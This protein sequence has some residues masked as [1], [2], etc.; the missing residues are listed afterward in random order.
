MA[1]ELPT[2]LWYRIIQFLPTTHQKTCLSV[3]KMHHDIA[4]KYV[5]SHVIISLGLWRADDEIE[6]APTPVQLLVAKRVARANYALLRH[7]MRTP[8]FACHVRKL[9]VQSYSFFEGNHMEYEIGT[10][11]DAIETLHNLSSF[12]WYGPLP[13]T[14]CEIM[15]ALRRS[16]GQKVVDIL[17]HPEI[18][19]HICLPAFTQLKSLVFVHRHGTHWPA[20]DAVPYHKTIHA[21][22]SA[23]SAT[24]RRLDVFGDALWGCPSAFFSNL[25]ELAIVFP[26]TLDGLHSVFEHCRGLGGFTLCTENDSSEFASILTAYPDAFPSLASFKLLS[27]FDFH[28]EAIRE[29][30]QFLKKKKLL[31]R[32]DILTRTEN[33]LHG[34]ANTPILEILP[35]LPRLEVLGLDIRPLKLTSAHV[36]LLQQYIPRQITAL[37]LLLQVESSSAKVGDWHTFFAAHAALQY[38]HIVTSAPQTDSLGAA[39]FDQPLPALELLGYNSRLRWVTRGPTPSGTT[40][41]SYSECWPRAKAYF[42]TVE[43]F[44]GY[45]DWEWLAR[46]H[47]QDDDDYKLWGMNPPDAWMRMEAFEEA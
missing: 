17:L 5:F 12:A 28:D 18:P 3:S 27:V 46:H 22:I 10:L 42:R 6:E 19:E 8:E 4:V 2:E 1:K 37:F 47:G 14:P 39:L 35:D 30:A 23:N 40:A 34:L 9:T 11:V 45:E 21:A 24:L 32:L 7:V 38:L 16:S 44:H 36:T 13:I 20:M 43:D 31:R 26:D 41:H 29:V 25:Y 15:D 33:V